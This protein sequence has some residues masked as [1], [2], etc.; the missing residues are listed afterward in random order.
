[1]IGGITPSGRINTTRDIS[2]DLPD[3]LPLEAQVFLMWL[4]LWKWGDTSSQGA[5]VAKMRRRP[6]RAQQAVCM[7]IAI[8]R[9]SAA[10][11]FS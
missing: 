6:M 5:R 4:V 2:I 10:R 7:E 1:L 11:R 8:A 9:R 3:E